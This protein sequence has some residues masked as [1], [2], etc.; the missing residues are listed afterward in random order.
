MANRRKEMELWRSLATLVFAVTVIVLVFIHRRE[1]SKLRGL[2][3]RLHPVGEA[4]DNRRIKVESP[5]RDLLAA[6]SPTAQK[7]AGD[8][9]LYRFIDA[10]ITDDPD[11]PG[12]MI[13]V[14]NGSIRRSL[15][16]TRSGDHWFFDNLCKSER[17]ALDSALMS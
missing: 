15:A 17:A 6:F 10:P 4:L 16:T 11:E 13:V 1:R 7:Q 2:A 3:R 5:E 9:T 14:K 8:F 12:I